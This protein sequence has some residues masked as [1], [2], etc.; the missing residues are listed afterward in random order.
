MHSK[1]NLMKLIRKWYLVFFLA[2][3]QS[4]STQE[5]EDNPPLTLTKLENGSVVTN[6]H[7]VSMVD[8]FGWWRDVDP[9]GQPTEHVMGFVETENAASEQF[10]TEHADQ[11]DQYLERIKA[12]VLDAS[13][14]RPFYLGGYE[15]KREYR[16][17]S[18]YPTYYAVGEDPAKDFVIL[19]LA[20]RAKDTNYYK[21]YPGDIKVS[22]DNQYI[23][24]AEDVV[25]LHE[26]TLHIQRIS[27]SPEIIVSIPNM[28]SYLGWTADSNNIVYTS[29]TDFSYYRY[30]LSDG[31]N[32]KIDGI[33]T[34]D[35]YPAVYD[36]A[37]GRY[38]NISVFID[39]AQDIWL[40]DSE[41]VANAPIQ[42]FSRDEGHEI[43]LE[44]SKNGYFY[45]T[46]EMQGDENKLFRF[47]LQDSVKVEHEVVFESQDGYLIDDT[48]HFN[49]Y[50]FILA[51]K[52]FEQRIYYIDK[53]T[54]E[55]HSV[56]FDQDMFTLD[57]LNGQDYA[58]NTV[59][60]SY[61]SYLT[62]QI[63]YSL[64]MASKSKTIVSQAEIAD[65]D[66][67]DYKVS[68]IFAKSVGDVDV[69]ITLI[70]H[71]DNID[72]PNAPLWLYVYGAYGD[73]LNPEFISYE[74]PILQD[75]FNIAYAHVRGGGE[76]GPEWHRQG[77]Q[78]DRKNTMEDFVSVAKYL[79]DSGVVKKG[80]IFASGASAAGQP[81]GY[82]LNELPDY[83]HSVV[84]WVPV[85]DFLNSLMD[86]NV[87]FNVTERHEFGNPVK[88]EEAFH[89]IRSF[90]AY[91][92]VRPQVY[93]N[94]YTTSALQDPGVP[95]WGPP[96]WLYRIRANQTNNS[97]TL[98]H[99]ENTGHVKTG[100]YGRAHRCAQVFTF[101]QA[102]REQTESGE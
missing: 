82:G 84:A 91:D 29:I 39:G 8:E 38:V 50:I 25:G 3:I 2:L 73:S 89:Y 16:D 61:E 54:N 15:V 66:P 47:K 100:R 67:A 83:F 58:S 79:V 9:K 24:W 63:I 90:S 88:S 94:I 101:F 85:V 102:M 44:H 18:E 52:G 55:S 86:D 62:P 92:N 70:Q 37:S 12:N 64:D 35:S 53:A 72:S 42:I 71:K 1:F 68:R 95:Y 98:L 22:P 19:D 36:T 96:K 14:D 51:S 65:Y 33:D 34:A 21:V 48:S 13:L 11:V 76:L 4:C 80:N 7:G 46:S 74:M 45:Y 23:A 81:L 20:E 78:M 6:V 10:F 99:I 43:V 93:P 26:F 87:S 59:L 30:N 75:G 49:D 28:E 56:I 60:I 5:T 40:L 27:P 17:G 57:F 41:N 69:P 31:T 97:T 32:I 77:K